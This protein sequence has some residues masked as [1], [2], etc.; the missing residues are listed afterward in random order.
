MHISYL[1]ITKF[2]VNQVKF[3]E[4]EMTDCYFKGCNGGDYR[5]VSVLMSFIDKLSTRA[6]Y[7]D[8]LSKKF[9][10]RQE[11]TPDSFEKIK[12]TGFVDVTANT[13]EVS[14]TQEYI[15]CTTVTAA[16]AYTTLLQF[17]SDHGSPVPHIPLVISQTIRA[18]LRQSRSDWSIKVSGTILYNVQCTYSLCE[19]TA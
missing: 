8:Y 5:M 14:L 2:H 11:T 15:A 3:S 7:G 16:T 6:A 10:C 19:R 1:L 9:T 18:I 17:Q 13:V 12:V 4:Q